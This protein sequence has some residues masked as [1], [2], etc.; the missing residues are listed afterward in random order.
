MSELKSAIEL[1][2]DRAKWPSDFSW[3]YSDSCRCAK[4]LIAY[5]AGLDTPFESPELA[6]RLGIKHEDSHRIFNQ[7][8]NE[9]PAA[10]VTPEVVARELELLLV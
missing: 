8:H 10:A 9:Q 3:D 4:G 6:T 7:M 1:L 2:R 5:I